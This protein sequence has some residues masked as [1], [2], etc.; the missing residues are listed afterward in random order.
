MTHNARIFLQ[1]NENFTLGYLAGKSLILG[2][3]ELQGSTAR[4]ATFNDL[5]GS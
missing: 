5:E 1:R 4:R 2:M 3:A